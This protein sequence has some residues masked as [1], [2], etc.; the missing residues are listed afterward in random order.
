MKEIK[1]KTFNT[2]QKMVGHYRFNNRKDPKAL[3][4]GRD[5]IMQMRKYCI[6]YD[7]FELGYVTPSHTT[8]FGIR[9]YPTADDGVIGIGDEVAEMKDEAEDES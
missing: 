2:I 1:D 4:L 5:V 8:L 9:V 3:F 6:L 7:V